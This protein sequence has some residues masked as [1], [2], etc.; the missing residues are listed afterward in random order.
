MFAFIHSVKRTK[1]KGMKPPLCHFFFFFF[2]EFYVNR[3]PT[4]TAGALACELSED[5]HGNL[6]R[7]VC[8]ERLWELQRQSGD[9]SHVK[10]RSHPLEKH[11]KQRA[12]TT[13]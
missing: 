4:E 12:S 5:H 2:L 8:L 1:E 7:E 6:R 13:W 9:F 11:T 3:L 10:E